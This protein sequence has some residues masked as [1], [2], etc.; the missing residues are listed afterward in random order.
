MK[1][2]ALIALILPILAACSSPTP[3]SMGKTYM[4]AVMKNDRDAITSIIAVGTQV[5]T[6]WDARVDFIARHKAKPRVKHIEYREL[7]CTDMQN[8]IKSCGYRLMSTSV[9]GKEDQGPVYD[10]R[11]D[12]KTNKITDCLILEI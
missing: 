9:E 6:S 11:I 5:D 8:D 7:G 10:I 12:K 4:D 1:R 2:K 3:E